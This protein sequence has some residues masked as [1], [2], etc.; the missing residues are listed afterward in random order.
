MAM[1]VCSKCDAQAPKWSGRCLEC[2]AWGT[3]VESEKVVEAPKKKITGLKGSSAAVKTLGDLANVS[4]KRIPVPGLFG[5][6]IFVKGIV[7]GSL[8]LVTGDPGTGKSTICLQL[9]SALSAEK[10]LYVSAEEALTQVK[11]RAGRLGTFGKE[12]LLA[13]TTV[14]EDIIATIVSHKPSV[15][16]IDS[17]QTITSREV[18]SEAGSINQVRS[19]AGMLTQ[20]ARDLGVAIIIIGHVTKEGDLAGPKTLEHIVDAVYYLESDRS[21]K[22]RLFRTT[23][24][25]YGDS[26]GVMVLHLTDKGFAEVKDAATIFIHDYQPKAGSALTITQTNEQLFFIEIQALVGKSSFGYAKR[27]ASGFPKQR[28]ELLL[29]IMK[30]H[31]HV[32]FDLYD[33]YV[34]VAGGFRVSEPAMDTAVALAVVS[35]LK[36]LIIPKGTIV[37]GELGLAGELRQVKDTAGR[38]REIVDNKFSTVI[39]PALASKVQSKLTLHACGTLADVIRVLGW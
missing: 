11:E 21:S 4:V 1:F 17:L 24:N 20:A 33:V 12:F 28:L 16:F 9:A 23:K 27:T 26:G 10:V 14:V 13:D 38:L 32:D 29:A 15:V 25:R 37:F 36:D 8:T 31:L 2:G 30:K 6:R 39:M 34:N 18:G 7:A 3:L 19:I 35:S 22:Y 5:E